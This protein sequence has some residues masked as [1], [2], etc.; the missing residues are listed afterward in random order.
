MLD[1]P[2][3]RLIVAS[4][5]RLHVARTLGTGPVG[6]DLPAAAAR[7]RPADDG[8]ARTHGLAFAP[9]YPGGGEVETVR[10][11]TRL[12]LCCRVTHAGEPAGRVVTVLI[13]GRPPQVSTLPDP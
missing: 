8:L 9:P 2:A 4:A 11:G 7:L 12:V 10:G 6:D 3:R 13:P 5:L 1:L